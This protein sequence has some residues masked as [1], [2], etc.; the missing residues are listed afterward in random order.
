MPSVSRSFTTMASPEAAYA[1]LADFRNTEEWDPG[2]QACERVAGDGGVG[3]T[4]RNVS[5]FLGRQ[6]EVMYTTAE[7]APPRRVHLRGTND[8]FEG[9]DI[10]EIAASGRGS[11]VSY[12]AEMSFSGLARLVTP[13]VAVY[14]P[15][16]ASRTVDQLRTCLDRQQDPGP[17][18]A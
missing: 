17:L 10:F 11:R 13:V 7:L 1:Y 5:R 16:L 3:T 4:Y 9:H 6:V 12:T 15:T 2:T 18:S 14:L 8:Q